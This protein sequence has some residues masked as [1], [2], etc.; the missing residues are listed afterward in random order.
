MS[1]FKYNY[2]L[3]KKTPKKEQP[4]DKKKKKKQCNDEDDE[5]YVEDQALDLNEEDDYNINEY[6]LYNDISMKSIQGLLKFIK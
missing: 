5:Y 6:Y 4:L 1:R 3:G 2:S